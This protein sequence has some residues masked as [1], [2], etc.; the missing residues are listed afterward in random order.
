MAN[1]GVWATN[2]VALTLGFAMFGTFLLVPTLLEL[3]AVTG[4]GFGKSVSQAGL[5]LL[6]TVLMMVVFG[7][8]SGLLDRRFGPKVPLFLGTV[9]GRQRV[10]PARRHARPALAGRRLRPAHRRRHRPGLRRHVERHHRERARH[11][12]R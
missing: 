6:P 1:R 8:L 9:A 3:P 5:F 10:R 4:Y 12:D 2:L 7:P 11:A